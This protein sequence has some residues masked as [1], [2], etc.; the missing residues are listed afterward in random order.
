M[1]KKEVTFVTKSGNE[2][3]LTRPTADE[4]AEITD[5]FVEEEEKE[6]IF[7][8]T[9]GTEFVLSQL[10]VKDQKNIRDLTD[11]NKEGNPRKP[12][13]FL[14]AWTRGCVSE[15][16][17]VDDLSI[18]ERNEI[19]LYMINRNATREYPAWARICLPKNT[20]IDTLPKEDLLEIGERASEL[21][22]M[23]K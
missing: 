7:K 1:K 6:I 20:D 3:K 4:C 13:S 23:G 12:A 9:S 15:D 21:A 11:L 5:S 19:A 8:S 16:V 2:Y 10:T 22:I 18:P 17:D 14:L